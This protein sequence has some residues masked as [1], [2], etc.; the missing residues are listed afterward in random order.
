MSAN[1]LPR[2]YRLEEYVIDAVLGHGGFGITYL[3]RDTR[4]N[5]K[6]AIK[7]Y[8]PQSIATRT[9]QSTIT[10]IT[11]GDTRGP[12]DYMWG[13]REFLKEA[14]ALATFK[15]NH[16]VRVLRFLEANGTA[17]MVMDYEEGESLADYLGRSGGYLGEPMILKVFLPIL[18]GLQAVHDAGLLHLDIKPDNIYLRGNGQPMLID[19]GS[20]Q[21]SQAGDDT[22]RKVALTPAYSAIEHYPNR[23]KQG[24][25]TDV[26]SI[27]ATLYRC[28]T[29][30]PPTDVMERY[31]AIKTGD[32]DPLVPAVNFER[33]PYSLYIRECIDQ[34]LKLDPAERP[35]SAAALQQGLMGKSAKPADKAPPTN[36]FGSG[37]IG[38]A[39]V[40]YDPKAGKRRKRGFLEKLALSGFLLAALGIFSVQILRHFGIISDTEINDR[41]SAGLALAEQGAEQTRRYVNR[42][43]L[44][45]PDRPETVT[46]N[47]PPA[48]L[49]PPPF[50]SQRVLAGNL[51]GHAERITAL[52]FLHDSK[53]LASA[54]A[55]GAVRVWSA[56]DGQLRHELAAAPAATVPIAASADGKW[57][58]VVTRELD[59]GLWRAQSASITTTLPIDAAVPDRLALSSDGRLLAAAHQDGTVAVWE[60][61]SRTVLHRLPHP[62]QALR[63]LA[64]APSALVLATASADGD[65]SYWSM[66]SGKQLGTLKAHDAEI[67]ALAYTPDGK[68]LASGGTEHS[69]KLWD[70]GIDPRD[71]VL[72]GAPATVGALAVSPDGRWLLAAGEDGGLQL[73]DLA[74]DRQ[75]AGPSENG[76]VLSA[77]AIS[78]DARYLATGGKDKRV[79]LWTA[80][81]APSANRA[82][83]GAAH[84]QATIIKP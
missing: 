75:I 42:V 9:P 3:A 35:Q 79:R 17:Y 13:L 76:E 44:R 21:R 2:N 77:L 36:S 4:L 26:Y 32:E 49:P 82:D 7:E 74:Q 65:I 78:P 80:A 69:L 12:E 59:I 23:G 64:F 73:W 5:A 28:V 72:N 27:G 67:L 39:R 60:V 58:A 68:W 54:S 70:T 6:V 50:E 30:L 24:P 38:E 62:Q 16:I 40:A 43:I 46:V 71:R 10:P 48:E 29:G 15:D 22:N 41:I 83:T 47:P 55:D 31:R 63:A 45:R 18:S 61:E 14:R 19:F 51:S 52:A 33:P 56:D 57:L 81:T 11:G 84:R 8:F 20:V 1:A 34:A 25:W 53:L 66:S 37:Y